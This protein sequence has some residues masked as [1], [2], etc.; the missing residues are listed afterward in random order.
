[1]LVVAGL[2][3][4]GVLLTG[5]AT[6]SPESSPTAS[7]GLLGA[8]MVRPGDEV[9]GRG[10]VVADQGGYLLCLLNASSDV[11]YSPGKQPPPSCSPIAVRLTGVDATAVPGWKEENGV[12]IALDVRVR[13]HWTGQSI[14]VT[15]ISQPPPL[16]PRYVLPCVPSSSLPE[17]SDPQLQESAA[18][19]LSAAIANHSDLYDDLWRGY[20]EGWVP[21]SPA[22]ST[23]GSAYVVGT[24]GDVVSA[25]Q[26]MS[27][28]YPYPLCVEKVDFS[29]AQLHAAAQRLAQPPVWRVEVGADLDRVIV[30]LAVLDQAAVNRI[31]N[32]A[33]MVMVQPLI[34]RIAG[35]R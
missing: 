10:A 7:L 6:G 32:D 2:L 14:E 19:A 23:Q 5:T 18:G 31:A 26:Q 16:Q 15:G 24:T 22:P 21:G 27:A 28:I 25:R 9:E 30:E 34:R 29:S 4:R 33:E 17:P 1:V 20:P 3:A 11:K 35:A 8:Q 12:G 13:G